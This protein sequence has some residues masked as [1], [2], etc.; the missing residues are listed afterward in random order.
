MIKSNQKRLN[1]WKIL[2]IIKIYRT[3]INK[4][5]LLKIQIKKYLMKIN[6]QDAIN[7][8]L[9]NKKLN[10]YTQLSHVNVQLDIAI[11]VGKIFQEMRLIAV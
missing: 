9:N 2:I 7:F 8:L 6:V 1:N 4:I 3:A 11:D 5:R 10:K